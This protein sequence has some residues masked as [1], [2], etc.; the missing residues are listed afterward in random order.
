[1][2]AFGF[3]NCAAPTSCNEYGKEIA[4]NMAYLNFLYRI[5]FKKDKKNVP[6]DI[7]LFTYY[8]FG[9]QWNIALWFLPI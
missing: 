2:T 7:R 9:S 6:S 1:M 4:D 3:L 8:Y 5:Q